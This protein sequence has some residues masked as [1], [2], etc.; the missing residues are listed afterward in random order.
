[1]PDDNLLQ[2]WWRMFGPAN[3]IKEVIEDLRDE[4]NVVLCLPEHACEG[5]DRILER[6]L[7]QV[8][9]ML[10]R[11]RVNNNEPVSVWDMFRMDQP[12]VI[13][14]EDLSESNWVRLVK[15][16]DLNRD[17]GWGHFIRDPYVN[18]SGERGRKRI[19]F[20]APLKGKMA[21][22]KLSGNAQ[23]SCH[24]WSGRV[25][26]LDMFFFTSWLLRDT[27]V[28]T[29]FDDKEKSL[30]LKQLAIWMITHLAMSDPQVSIR[31]AKDFKVAINLEEAFDK[32]LDPKKAL[33]YIAQDRK[34]QDS[35]CQEME[36]NLSE[37]YLSD[38]YWQKGMKDEFDGREQM[39]SA[40]LA[41]RGYDEQI[42]SRL[43]LAQVAAIFPLLE[44]HR[45][46][47]L[48]TSATWLFRIGQ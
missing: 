28:F 9:R 46:R 44:E 2:E 45:G 32:I 11:L 27:E 8:G 19:L 26:Q 1:M 48:R 4:K 24:K 12:V 3:F 41:L 30:F 38:W 39:H 31:L 17:A 35:E 37:Q 7:P 13:W 29:R 14:L 36:Q 33:R 20:C 18:H 34:W 47:S 43:W 6:E 16:G 5:I 25:S 22:A 42:D 15:E 23:L 10:L 40:I 21:G